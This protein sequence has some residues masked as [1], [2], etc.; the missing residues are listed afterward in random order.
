MCEQKLKD[1]KIRNAK[2]SWVPYNQMHGMSMVHGVN[3]ASQ[4]GGVNL[5][6]NEVSFLLLERFS[7]IL[8]VAGVGLVSVNGN[9]HNWIF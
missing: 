7:S 5:E 6:I 3:S 4:G 9:P 1:K 8:Q 2:D